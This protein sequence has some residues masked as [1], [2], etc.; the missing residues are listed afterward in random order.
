MTTYPSPT[1]AGVFVN[2][3]QALGA[4]GSTYS[5]KLD[6]SGTLS[7]I[8]TAG[9]GEVVD[10]AITDTMAAGAA[11][12]YGFYLNYTYGGTGA[13]GIKASGNRVGFSTQMNVNGGTQDK[14]LGYT[15]GQYSPLWSYSYANTNLGGTDLVTPGAQFGSMW[16]GIMSA[17]LNAGSTFWSGVLG[18]EI[19][20]MCAA[21]ASCNETK[22]LVIYF[23]PGDTGTSTLR[24]GMSIS[25]MGNVA[26][27]FTGQGC[28]FGISIGDPNGAWPIKNATGTLIGVLGSAVA[29]GPYAAQY[30]INFSN[31]TF[32]TAAFQSNGF[33][34]DGSGLIQT[35]SAIII[36]NNAASAALS[37]ADAAGGSVRI[38]ADPSNYLNI[39][40]TSAA[41]ATLPVFKVPLHTSTPIPLFPYPIQIGDGV[42]HAGGVVSGGTGAPGSGTPGYGVGGSIWMRSD[43]SVGARIYV[44]TG[45]GWNAVAG[46]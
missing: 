13:D 20:V 26:G 45:A 25:G 4:G 15:D 23:Y 38:F 31:I 46:V 39:C 12:L 6:L 43:G 7:G 36:N 21:G 16:G 10:M 32:G 24:V 8:K 44:S 18:A 37:F 1:F 11:G 2:Q 40:G 14:S 19:D 33:S 5:A 28:D 22:G 29:T 17:Q 3:A 41:G 42:G 34:V 9:Y 35:T 27:D 30:G